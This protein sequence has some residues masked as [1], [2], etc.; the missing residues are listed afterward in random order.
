[1]YKG[2]IVELDALYIL[3]RPPANEWNTPT[4][5]RGTVPV[6]V[7]AEAKC[8]KPSVAPRTPRRRQQVEALGSRPWGDPLPVTC[9][10]ADIE[11]EKAAIEVDVHLTEVLAGEMAPDPIE[12]P[13]VAIRTAGRMLTF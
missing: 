8:G 11:L 12:E 6:I 13:V 4:K 5:A 10:G 2:V 9:V 7:V 1:M 3:E